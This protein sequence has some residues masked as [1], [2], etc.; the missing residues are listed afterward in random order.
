MVLADVAGIDRLAA[1]ASVGE[2]EDG[3]DLERDEMNGTHD[4]NTVDG[5]T[6]LE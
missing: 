4:R 5:L 3:A 2:M 1:L 6:A